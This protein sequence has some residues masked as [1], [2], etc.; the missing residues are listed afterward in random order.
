VRYLTYEGV[1]RLLEQLRGKAEVEVLLNGDSTSQEP[2]SA[3]VK[4]PATPG[5]VAPVAAPAPAKAS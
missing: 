1:R 2:A 3:P 5:P 4:A